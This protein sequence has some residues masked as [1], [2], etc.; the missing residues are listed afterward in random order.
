MTTEEKRILIQE[1]AVFARATYARTELELKGQVLPK[2]EHP[3]A[4]IF[5]LLL[6]FVVALVLITYFQLWSAVGLI[7]GITVTIGII[8]SV[9][10]NQKHLREGCLLHHCPFVKIIVWRPTVLLQMAQ[11]DEIYA[12][13]V[14][15]FCPN[16]YP[17]WGRFRGAKTEP[18]EGSESEVVHIC[19]QCEEVLSV[20]W[21]KLHDYWWLRREPDS[22]PAQT[23]SMSPPSE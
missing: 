13:V 18:F 6:P 11:R 19:P 9:F 4:C 17:R 12:S 20:I 16:V 15:K 2:P 23:G 8:I 3:L 5:W 1:V 21:E 10:K 14:E 22:A 7:F